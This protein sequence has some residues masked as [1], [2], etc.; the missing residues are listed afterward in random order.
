M[1][2]ITK[3]KNLQR[4]SVC[5][6]S[7]P[8]SIDLRAPRGLFLDVLGIPN[9][10]EE[11]CVYVRRLDYGHGRDTRAGIGSHGLCGNDKI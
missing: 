2:D 8:E 6:T 10:K 11:S 5:A 4:N 3:G 7:E 9:H 1:R